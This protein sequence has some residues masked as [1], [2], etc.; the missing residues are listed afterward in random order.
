ML[1]ADATAAPLVVHRAANLNQIRVEIRVITPDGV[2]RHELMD[3]LGR[4]TYEAIYK[5]GMFTSEMPT[6][7]AKTPGVKSPG[8]Q[9]E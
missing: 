9:M 6:P 7:V 8:E 3:V 1:L 4:A 2:E 5:I